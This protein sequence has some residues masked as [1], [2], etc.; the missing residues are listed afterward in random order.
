MTVQKLL[1]RLHQLVRDNPEVRTL[2]VV[3]E[4]LDKS[5]VRVDVVRHDQTGEL[6]VALIGE[7]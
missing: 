2:E 6:L 7:K 5:Y 4:G 3:D 1:G